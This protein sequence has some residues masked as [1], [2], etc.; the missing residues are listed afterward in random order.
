MATEV[1]KKKDFTLHDDSKVEVKSLNIKKLREFMKVIKE[2]ETIEEEIDSLGLMAK[3]TAIAVEPNRP[4]LVLRDEEGNLLDD[5]EKLEE[6]L[7]VPLMWEIFEVAG[8]VKMGDPNQMAAGL[9]GR[10]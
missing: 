2:L 5:Q 1:P 8:G 4:D 3:A 6:V 9:V 7:D 10:N